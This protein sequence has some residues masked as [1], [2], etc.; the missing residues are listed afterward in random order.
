MRYVTTRSFLLILLLWA[1]IT[2]LDFNKAFHIDETFH[3]KAAQWIEHH[4]GRPMSGTVNWGMDPEPIHDFNQPPG[5]FYLV[6]AT[7]HLFGYAEGPMHAMR[8]VFTLLALLCFHRLARYRA[9]RHALWLTALF[10]LCPAFL[11][12]QGLMTD[13]PLLLMMLLFFN[14]LLVPGRLPTGARYALAGLAL[15][16]A[17]FIKYSTLPLLLAFPLVMVL[18]REWRRLPLALVPVLLIVAWSIWNL[19]EYGQVHLLDRKPG[20]PSPRGIFVK[21]LALLSAFGAVAPFTPAFL[22][23]LLPKRAGWLFPAWIIGI[24]AAVVFCIAAYTGAIT[25]TTSDQVL[26]LS[27]TLN[28]VLIV[29]YCVRHLPRS[30]DPRTADTWALALWAAGLAFFL[31]AFSPM[32]ATRHVLL[33]VPPV[34]LLI[35]P[36]LDHAR[37]RVKA[38]AVA[39]TAVLGVLL[40]VSDK[41]YADFYRQQAPRV[42]GA[43][44]ARTAGTV[45]SLGHWGWQWYAEQAGMHTYAMRESRPEPGD[46]LVIPEDYD[47]QVLAP[48]IQTE[49][50]ATWDG[51]PGADTFFCVEQFAGMYT[52]SFAKLPWSLSR[53]HHKIIRAYRV[54]AVY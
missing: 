13:V 9:P 28:G 37:L 35:A 34:L 10:A 7:G 16:G 21:I 51:A 4:P 26:R 6:A 32:M 24:A 33:I 46:I 48:G 22:G 1:G 44:K 14:F 19:Q 12:N 2:A 52:S 5:F 8:S 40:T 30:V 54:T 36:A 25:E 41:A 42:A 11:V 29:A 45:W 18:R 17:M 53:S 20:D 39:C 23:A 43:M 38:L 49:P 3:L 27:F 50:I 31:V 15:A 47:A